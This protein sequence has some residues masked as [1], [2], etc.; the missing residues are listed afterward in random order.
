MQHKEKSREGGWVLFLS[1]LSGVASSV[2]HW[3]ILM[4]AAAADV[5]LER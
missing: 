4:F 2:I 1:Y 3:P 5:L